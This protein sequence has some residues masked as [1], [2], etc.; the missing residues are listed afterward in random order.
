MNNTKYTFL[1]PAYKASFFEEALMSIKNQTYTDF[2]VIVSDDCSPEDLKSIY[3]KVCSDDSRF[4]YR[5]NEENMGSKSLVSHWN[6]LV[7]K[8]DTEYLIMASDDDVY[9]PHFL[10]EIDTLT[11]K[12]PKVDLFR[13][14]TNRVG[15]DGLVF[16]EDTLM[17][18]YEEQVD[19][20]YFYYC[21]NR[22][23]CL[24]NFVFRCST[25]KKIGGFVD[26]P[27]A[28]G[29]DDATII[30]TSYNGICNTSSI[31]FSFRCSGQNISG[32]LQKECILKKLQA[33]KNNLKFFKET[34]GL[35]KLNN[36]SISKWRYNQ[37]IFFYESECLSQIK[38]NSKILSFKDAYYN[39]RF[40]K[41]EEFTFSNLE[42]FVYWLKWI[43]NN[44]VLWI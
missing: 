15:S 36:T 3:D 6:L 14:R 16:N 35:V 33:K 34:K 9:A 43:K 17:P 4:T 19:F 20:L 10:T 5:R 27:L 7:N 2:K 29:S 18:E 30:K 1:L 38:N 8:C 21:H 32:N 37:F 12:Y 31:L 11:Q 39:Y 22:L 42:T 28:W 44:C 13:G 25:I 24:A 26:F 40:L 23:K 41:K